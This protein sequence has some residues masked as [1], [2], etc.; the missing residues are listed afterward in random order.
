MKIVL[1]STHLNTGGIVSYMYTLAQGFIERGHAVHIVT[2]GGER[3]KDFKSLGANILNLNIQT[4]SELS[5][6]I[7]SNIKILKEYCLNNSINVIHAQTRITQVMGQ[8]LFKKFSYPYLSTCHGFFKPKWIRSI[9]PCWGN[10][11]IAISPAVVE[12]LKRDFHVIDNKIKLVQ[13]GIDLNRFKPV[14]NRLK[15]ELRGKLNIDDRMTIGIIARLSDVKGQD[16]LVKSMSKVVQANKDAQLLLIGEGKL[17]KSLKE[18]VKSLNIQNN[19][20]FLSGHN[21]LEDYYRILDVFVMPSRQEGLGLSVMEA[22]ASG[23]AVVASK[24]GGM[25]SL[26]EHNKTGIFVEP[27]NVKGLASALISLLDNESKRIELG[28]TAYEFAL[29]NYSKEIMIDK[30]LD[31]YKEVI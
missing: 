13:S 31:V 2:G 25:V 6:K 12:H 15:S 4:K 20:F 5:S 28:R 11:V 21:R 3:E 22:Q 23:L 17:E 8:L 24:V 14:D 9:F 29:K 18:L 27:D 19:V 10:R 30:T 7:Y 26:I 1:L 16:I